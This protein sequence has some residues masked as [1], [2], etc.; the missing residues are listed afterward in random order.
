MNVH[1]K[2]T[3]KHSKILPRIEKILERL[4]IKHT[5]I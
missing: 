2:I 1:A 4:D 5:T 3:M